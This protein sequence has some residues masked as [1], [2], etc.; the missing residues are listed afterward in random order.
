M[1]RQAGMD[2]TVGMGVAEGSWEIHPGAPLRE[3]DC[4][5]SQVHSGPP[6]SP[7]RAGGS[8][9]EIVVWASSRPM[10]FKCG[11]GVR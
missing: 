2:R 10:V 6:Q 5:P 9:V 1:G 11:W 4:N 8:Q 7:E 3:P